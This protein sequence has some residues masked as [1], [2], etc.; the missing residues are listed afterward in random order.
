MMIPPSPLIVKSFTP[1]PPGSIRRK[2]DA[3][4]ARS[5]A[6]QALKGLGPARPPRLAMARGLRLRRPAGRPGG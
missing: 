2:P 5:P 3:G 4:P 6:R 1:V